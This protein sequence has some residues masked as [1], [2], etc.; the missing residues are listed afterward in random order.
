MD[1]IGFYIFRNTQIYTIYKNLSLYMSI[2]GYLYICKYIYKQ[3]KKKKPC[4]WKFEREQGS[5]KGRKKDKFCNYNLISKNKKILI[6]K[7]KWKATKKTHA[8]IHVHLH[9]HIHKVH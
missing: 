8:F 6:K 3:L 7:I 9:T 2:Y 5:I 4:T 1:Y